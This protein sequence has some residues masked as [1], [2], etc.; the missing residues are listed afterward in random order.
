[1]A[2]LLIEMGVTL[3]DHE[4]RLLVDAFE[5]EIEDDISICNNPRSISL[6]AFFVK[7]L[8]AYAF[9][10]PVTLHVVNQQHFALFIDCKEPL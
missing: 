4:M 8:I 7:L 9:A 5:P 10:I 3:K 2:S 6:L 1:M